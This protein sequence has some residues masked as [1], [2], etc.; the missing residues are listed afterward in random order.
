M[1]SH[2]ALATVATLLMA[3]VIVAIGDAVA[4][5]AP[6]EPVA[7][8]PPAGSLSEELD[9][10]DGVIPAPPAGDGE[11]P[12]EPPPTGSDMPVIP[13]PGTSGDRPGV[14]PE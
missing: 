1:A 14:Q 12:I 8:P 4:Q 9:R 11:M 3:G 10:T 13:P 7:A 2:A 6:S 5:P